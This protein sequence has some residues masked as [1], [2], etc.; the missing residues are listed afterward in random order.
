MPQGKN[1]QNQQAGQHNQGTDGDPAAIIEM[2]RLLGARASLAVLLRQERDLVADRGFL[3]ELGELADMQKD[4]CFAALKKAVMLLLI[5]FDQ[6][7]RQGLGQV[8]F[9]RFVHGSV[10]SK[11]IEGS[12]SIS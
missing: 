3:M 11:Q 7:R 4:A 10:R 2:H 9:I 8:D 1:G 6:F 5:P 12:D